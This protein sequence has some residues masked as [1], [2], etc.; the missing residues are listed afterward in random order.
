MSVIIAALIDALEWLFKTKLGQWIVAAFVFL[1]I[2]FG[3]S[4]L[5]V[6]PS[7]DAIK[8]LANGGVG[9][10]DL[11]AITLQWMGVLKFD[12]AITM[13]LSAVAT[14]YGVQA[15]KLFLQKRSI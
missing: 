4:K 7:L 8:A 11:A 2:S 9:S 14:K 1:G 13:I 6:Q 15:G 3:T 5:V 10:S 12:V